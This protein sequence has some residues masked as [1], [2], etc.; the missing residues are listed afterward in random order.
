VTE[1]EE[2]ARVLQHM[3]NA[4]EIFAIAAQQAADDRPGLPAEQVAELVYKLGAAMI[5]A[6]AVIEYRRR[7]VR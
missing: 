4:R 7:L 3:R 6:V 2:D 5:S 1:E